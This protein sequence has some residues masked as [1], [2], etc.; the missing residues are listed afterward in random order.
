MSAKQELLMWRQSPRDRE[1]AMIFL[2][3]PTGRL[4]VGNGM[5]LWLTAREAKLRE[6]NTVLGILDDS[7]GNVLIPGNP[8]WRITREIVA[9]GMDKFRLTREKAWASLLMAAELLGIE[10]QPACRS[11]YHARYMEVFDMALRA[12]LIK[13]ISPGCLVYADTNAIED[14]VMGE[15]YPSYAIERAAY[16][17]GLDFPFSENIYQIQHP[18]LFMVDVFDNYVPMHIRGQDILNQWPQ[19]VAP[20]RTLC[21]LF[22]PRP[23]LK[24][25]HV[26]VLHTASGVAMHKSQGT[27]EAYDFETWARRFKTVDERR[28]KLE[29]YIVGPEKPFAYENVVKNTTV[30]INEDG[31]YRHVPILYY[32]QV[33]RERRPY[34]FGLGAFVWKTAT[35]LGD[36]LFIHNEFEGECTS[37]CSVAGGPP[38]SKTVEVHE[39]SKEVFHLGKRSEHLRIT[40]KAEHT[41]YDYWEA[42]S[43]NVLLTPGAMVEVSAWIRGNRPVQ[44]VLAYRF[45]GIAGW[46]GCLRGGCYRGTGEWE[47][48]KVSNVEQM[49]SP[50]KF[51]PQF[52]ARASGYDG[53]QV[54]ELY[55]IQLDVRSNRG[56][57]DFYI[58]DLR[59]YT[60]L[61]T[62]LGG[63]ME[64]I[65]KLN[66][67]TELADNSTFT[68]MRT[69][70]ED[71][72]MGLASP[73]PAKRIETQTNAA[74]IFETYRDLRRDLV[75][76]VP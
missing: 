22:G 68:E 32:Y 53:T 66:K 28:R 41:S 51:G 64:D 46:G 3:N 11:Q 14:T 38:E 74:T 36:G 42:G 52:P 76:L 58:D 33:A 16:V 24:Y 50:D 9:T 25:V 44:L 30:Y 61:P 65:E 34:M 63:V 8:N 62:E 6:L 60:K 59:V 18:F 21:K 73:Y 35:E 27:S 72:K 19:E 10:I 20:F 69:I 57:V 23:P 67:H 17:M 37:L 13:E 39:M 45:R 70:I 40:Y 26:P 12:G 2:P 47:E 4:H 5:I 75:L 71:L 49:V 15:I 7:P 43:C 29:E 31:S 54:A 1:S 48:V 55:S 56:V